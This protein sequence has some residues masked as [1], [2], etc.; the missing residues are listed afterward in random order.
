MVLPQFKNSRVIIIMISVFI[1]QNNFFTQSDK[2][3]AF[4]TPGQCSSVKYLENIDF[5]TLI[6]MFDN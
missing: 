2:I 3:V 4:I 1:S 6:L 5:H